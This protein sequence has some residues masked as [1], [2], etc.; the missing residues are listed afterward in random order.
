MERQL[1]TS[2]A[3]GG[4]PALCCES[5]SRR[6]ATFTS[7]VEKTSSAVPGLSGLADKAD[8]LLVAG[9]LTENGRLLEAEVAGELLAASRLPVVAVLGNPDLRSLRR[10]A[11]RRV[12]ERRWI[13]VLDGCATSVR[14]ANGSRVASPGR[15]AVV[16]DSGRTRGLTRSTRGP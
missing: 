5:G 1:P 15:P 3:R 4:T 10:V 16:A 12:L 11:F 14:L 6:L 7:V 9:D 8:L 13:E 2:V